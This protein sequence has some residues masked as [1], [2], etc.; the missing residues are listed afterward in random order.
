MLSALGLLCCAA[1]FCLG[2]TVSANFAG[3]FFT[4]C[5]YPHRCHHGSLCSPRRLASQSTGL[6]AVATL[7][8]N[9]LNADS[10]TARQQV[11]FR[12]NVSQF[13]A[14]RALLEHVGPCGGPP[15]VE[16]LA[17]GRNCDS[18]IFAARGGVRVAAPATEVFE[19]FVDPVENQRMFERTIVKVNLRRL[20][21]RD[22]VA[23][24][25]LYEVSK[26]GRWRILGVPW[27]SDSTVY[28]L[29]DWQSFKIEFHLKEPGMMQHLSGFW[30][31]IP[32]SEQ[33][34]LIF[35]YTEAVPAFPV[36]QFLQAAASRFVKALQYE[37]LQDVRNY[38]A[39]L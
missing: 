38:F 5:S 11:T 39:N 32:V 31:V 27:T 28:A 33:E 7:A 6:K 18:G 8:G 3:S 26:T 13:T 17:I 14:E 21:Q 23:K 24:T 2:P 19:R 37:L 9:N 30:Q 15:E 35:Y 22:D 1:L 20:I 29:E 36:P 12:N 4:G 25:R 16:A 10:W 34:T